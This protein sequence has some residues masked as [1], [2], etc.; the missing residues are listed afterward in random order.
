MTTVPPNINKTTATEQKKKRQK[1]QT[2][3]DQHTIQE[4]D[5]RRA[6]LLSLKE[7]TRH[8]AVSDDFY[9]IKLSLVLKNNPKINL[10]N[11]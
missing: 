1:D 10:K 9:F 4:R 6:V 3:I 8:M 7:Y 11:L 5:R 2:Q